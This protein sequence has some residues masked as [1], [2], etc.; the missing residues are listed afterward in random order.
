MTNAADAL[1]EFAL[2]AECRARRN[3]LSPFMHEPA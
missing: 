1:A 3:A 2:I